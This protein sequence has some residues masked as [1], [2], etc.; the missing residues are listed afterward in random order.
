VRAGIARPLIEGLRNPTVVRNDR[1][2]RLL[3]FALTP[4]D[5][6]ARIALAEGRAAP[7]DRPGSTGS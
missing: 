6:A 5:D 3:P 7:S 1:L 2:P 4:F